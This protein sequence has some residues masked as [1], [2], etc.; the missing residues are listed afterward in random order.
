MKTNIFLNTF[1]G[2][3]SRFV[4]LIFLRYTDGEIVARGPEESAAEGNK[5]KDGDL[6]ATRATVV[7][8]RRA[9]SRNRQ[10]QLTDMRAL[11]TL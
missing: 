6:G 5:R 3:N 4:P 9:S 8:Q 10:N 11:T 2:N 7:A 1:T